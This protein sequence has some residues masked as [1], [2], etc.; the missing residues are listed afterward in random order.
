MSAP[1]RSYKDDGAHEIQR[2]SLQV[3]AGSHHMP[4][5]K[6]YSSQGFSIGDTKII[7]PVAV[8]P[9]GFFLW[10]VR[11]ILI[12]SYSYYCE[13]IS[14]LSNDIMNYC[15]LNNFGSKCM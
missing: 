15:T 14:R 12:D 8:L 2:T 9:R 4:I 13:I 5:V 10:K 11:I 6:S 7:G 1:R 3:V